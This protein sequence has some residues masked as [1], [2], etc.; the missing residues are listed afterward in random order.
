M[1]QVGVNLSAYI[2][3]QAGGRVALPP[4]KRFLIP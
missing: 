4:E 1:F 2:H 3:A